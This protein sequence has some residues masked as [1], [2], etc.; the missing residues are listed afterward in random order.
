[1]GIES[2]NTEVATLVA[3][4][5]AAFASIVVLIISLNAQRLSELRAAHRRNLD[6]FIADL[7]EAIHE[8]VACANI[9][10]KTKSTDANRNWRERGDLASKKLKSLRRQIRYPLWGIE[11]TGGGA[12][13]PLA[14]FG[15]FVLYRK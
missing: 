15:I 3:A 6:T 8:S 7:A 5:I 9:L 11:S 4:G 12:G 2:M 10:L 13:P 1:M 14:V